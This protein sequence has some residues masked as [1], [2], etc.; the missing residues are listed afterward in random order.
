MQDDKVSPSVVFAVF[1]GL[2]LLAA[3]AFGLVVV[4]AGSNSSSHRSA[5]SSAHAISSRA[6]QGSWAARSY[7]GRPPPSRPRNRM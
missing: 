2:A 4:Y 6:P 5:V 7:R 3:L 1:A